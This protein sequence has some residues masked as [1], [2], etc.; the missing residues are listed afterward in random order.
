MV[1]RFIARKPKYINKTI[2]CLILVIISFFIT[3][4]LLFKQFINNTTPNKVNEFLAL[5]TNNLIGE[6]SLYDLINFNLKSPDNLLKMS[7]SNAKPIE[8]QKP[9]VQKVSKPENK[10]LVYIYNTHQTEEYASG[11]LSYYN[12]KPTVYM[13]SNMLKKSLSH[14]DIASIVEEENLKTVLINNDWNYS[15]AYDVSQMWLDRSIKEHTSLKYFI[16]VHRDSV[17]SK[18]TINDK[19]YAK[20][21][22]V[23]GMNHDNYEQNES[24]MIKLNDY[25]NEHYKGLMRELFYGK[26]SV[27]NQNFNP[28]T[29][30]VEVGGIENTIDEVN[31]SI[32]ALAEALSNVIGGI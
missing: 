15:K 24:L 18:A 13:A 10:P 3:I 8:Y 14:Y 30:L 7:F 22:F 1:K 17:S 32:I 4:K 25:L 16:D 23:I 6:L 27:Y 2:L 31:N 29:I 21:M 9:V 26:R 28:N 5:S 11:N 20:M 19:T 12:I